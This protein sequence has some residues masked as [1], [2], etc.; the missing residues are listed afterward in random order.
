[1]FSAN[2]GAENN[3]DAEDDDDDEGN[4]SVSCSMCLQY[5]PKMD[6]GEPKCVGTVTYQLP[7]GHAGSERCR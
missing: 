7:S 4:R 3:H 6:H 1:M 2:D 5:C